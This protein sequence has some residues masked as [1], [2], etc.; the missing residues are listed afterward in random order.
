MKLG[1]GVHFSAPHLAV[2]GLIVCFVSVI[3]W[4]VWLKILVGAGVSLLAVVA[5]GDR[6]ITRWL[7][8][9]VGNRRRPRSPIL[10]AA[11]VGSIAFPGTGVAVRW[12]G[13][14]L[15]AL[16][17]LTP[18]PFT[19]TIITDR[20][21]TLHDDVVDTRLVENVLACLGFDAAGDV[22]S[23]GWRVARSAPAPVYGMYEQIQGL[24]PAPAFRRTW[25]VIRVDPYRVLPVSGWRGQGVAAVANAVAAAATRMAEA[26]AKAGVD[27]RTSSS[28][29]QFDA[30]TGVHDEIVEQRWSTLRHRGA[31]TTVFSAPGG[32]DA[33]WS[34]RADRTVTRT[35]VRVGVPART[36]VAL[37]TV[38]PI[39]R[40]PSGWMRLRG[41]QFDAWLGNTSIGDEHRSLPVGSAGVLVGRTAVD[42]YKVYVPFDVVES[43]LQ[44]ADPMLAT[45]VA[46]RA[47]A[48]GAAL[49]LPPGFRAHAASLG[50]VVGEPAFFEWAGP[51][52]RT[53]LGNQRGEHAIGFN[54]RM[55]VLPRGR[56]ALTPILAREESVLGLRWGADRGPV[57][58]RQKVTEGVFCD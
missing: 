4:P 54:P 22:V 40:D 48:V 56:I 33:W 51:G 55:I 30:L 50:A 15:V 17:A 42:D 49:C 13:D 25:V 34:V 24:D 45:H 9:A 39:E 38:R 8:L 1:I 41:T 19:P 43:V 44:V 37:T 27:A 21:V 52:V 57:D 29:D 14:D 26:L 10:S 5:V 36:V 3:G 47:A 28:F 16:V 20:G 2:A 46:V 35:R 58:R 11:Q 18:R 6:L 32:P 23:A 31:Y 53:W 12:E 7:S